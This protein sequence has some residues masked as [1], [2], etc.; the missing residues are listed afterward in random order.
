M[1]I[2]VTGITDPTPLIAERVQVETFGAQAHGIYSNNGHSSLTDVDIKVNDIAFGLAA[3]G[4]GVTINMQGGSIDAAGTNAFGVFT[5]SGGHIELDNVTIQSLNNTTGG[6]GIQVQNGSS[7][8]IR[9]N[10]SVVTDG[11][12]GF[13]LRF[14]G[15]TA[16]NSISVDNSLVWAQDSFAAL[17]NG[18]TD[19]LNVTGGSVVQGERGLIFAGDCQPAN[20]GI[21]RGS[22]L[23]VNADNAQLVGLADVTDASTLRMNLDNHALWSIRPSN[24][25]ATTSNVSFVHLDN[26]AGIEFDQNGTGLFQELWVGKGTLGGATTVWTGGNDAS[27]TFNTY[28]NEGGDWSNQSTD[29]LY[30]E[31]DVSGQ[32]LVNIKQIIGNS[33]GWTSPT[34]IYANDE[35]ISL[36]QV[37]GQ[38]AEARG[39]CHHGRAALCL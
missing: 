21:L 11:A 3:H 26:E 19:F 6:R 15:A 12:N 30:I 18:G 22:K 24:T 16:T 27:I 38:A 33:G 17:A 4:A 14:F 10:S 29:R 32:T 35:G 8:D 7:V 2:W 20:C 1:G 36:I 13:A 31:G 25:G 39:L 9:N 5:N 28:L 34:E 23:E 37:S